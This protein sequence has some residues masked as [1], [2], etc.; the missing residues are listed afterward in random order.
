MGNSPTGHQT[1][2]RRCLANVLFLFWKC[3]WC[4]IW[5][6]ILVHVS[7]IFVV[8]VWE[9]CYNNF[10]M[11]VVDGLDQ[12]YIRVPGMLD[13]FRQKCLMCWFLLL[14]IVT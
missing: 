9:N 11:C 10:C 12:C 6:G 14:K 7:I 8:P 5:C 2:R 13:E 3:C 4:Y 1:R